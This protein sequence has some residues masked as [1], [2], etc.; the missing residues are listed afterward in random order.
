[1]ADLKI[2]IKKLYEDL[3]SFDVNELIKK[4]NNIKLDD[5][6]NIKLN[7][8]NSISKNQSFPFLIGGLSFIILS[9]C[10]IYPSL[11]DF[12]KL[13][14]KANLY[15]NNSYQIPQLIEDRDRLLNI[16]NKTEVPFSNLKKTVID[17]N[18]LILI[19]RMISEVALKS[20]VKIL[21]LIPIKED[22]LSLCQ[23]LNEEE[24]ESLGLTYM[25]MDKN[26]NNDTDPFMQEDLSYSEGF[27][28]EQ[29]PELD[30]NNS[31]PS[32]SNPPEEI[33]FQNNYLELSLQAKY[34]NTI[35]FIRLLQRYEITTMPV[36]ISIGA[37]LNQQ[38]QSGETT[39]GNMNSKFIINIPTQE[40]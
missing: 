32:N 27:P 25:D 29:L 38:N 7:D 39:S 1:M 19:N 14:R 2:K 12:F 9:F 26:Q 24:Q 11:S 15:E 36:C 16:L 20:D 4:L 22:P 21:S 34:F 35:K 28:N 33:N 40:Q 6:K 23:A 3:N 37:S 31:F 30:P 13:R 5:L 10:L 18:Q 8:L 17:N